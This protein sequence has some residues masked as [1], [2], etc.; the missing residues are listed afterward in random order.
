MLDSASD[1]IR[2]GLDR[3]TDALHTGAAVPGVSLEVDAALR[4]GRVGLITNSSADICAKDST[5][6]TSGFRP[7]FS[8]TA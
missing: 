7:T 3:L 4:N 5:S 1:P 8:A 6:M 2:F